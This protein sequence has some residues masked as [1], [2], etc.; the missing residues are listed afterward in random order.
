MNTALIGCGRIGYILESDPL[1]YKPCTHYGGM[2]SAGITVTHACDINIGRLKGFARASKIPDKNLYTRSAE[3]IRRVRPE[4]VVI[5]TWTDSHESIAV[6][7]AKNGARAVIL[8]K[9]IAPSL[10]K[11][12]RILDA[13]ETYGTALIINHERRYDGRYRALKKIIASGKIGEVRTVY[14][15]ILT[16]GYRGSSRI[17]EG[18]GP[19]LHDGTHLIDIVRHLFGEIATVQ[20]RFSRFSRNTGFE[21][22]AAAWCR[23]ETGVD[24]FIEAGGGRDYFVFELDISGTDGRI[25]IGNGYEKMCLKKK[26]VIYRGFNDLR[27]APFPS[28]RKNNPFTELY[29]EVKALMKA[30]GSGVTSSGLD[31]YRALEAVHAI[32]LS[33][34]RG[35]KTVSLPLRPSSVDLKK[36]FGLD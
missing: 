8:E 1:R 32:Y 11:A 7:A 27:D 13:C 31:G 28:I 3:L 5:A 15:R 34:F 2:S 17:D 19:L 24:V 33:S 26:S 14:A 18:G 6:D 9:P 36:I 29:R 30:P 21:D 23:T 20:G 12:R 4:I 22:A 25:V 16:G 35:S 10:K